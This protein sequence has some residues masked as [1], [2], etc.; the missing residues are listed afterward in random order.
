MLTQEFS[1]A[2]DSPL[3]LVQITGVEG[4]I[5]GISFSDSA[6]NTEEKHDVPDL[7]HLCK[8]QLDEYFQGRRQ[9]FDSLPLVFRATDFQQAVWEHLMEVPFGETV[10]YRELAKAAGHDGAA[11]AVGTA[12]NQNPLCII[13]PCH[14]V[15]PSGGS[16]GEYAGGVH[17]KEW[18]LKHE[19]V[20]K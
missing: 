19:G 8:N 4:G 11:R 7:F 17:R 20:H 6:L 5:S 9:I 3:G 18:L 2:F 13:V 10:T 16:I 12:M 1:L 14:R 15:I